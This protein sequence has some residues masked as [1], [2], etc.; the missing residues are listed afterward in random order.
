[1]PQVQQWTKAIVQRVMNGTEEIVCHRRMQQ[2][3]NQGITGV[4]A[5]G[6]ASLNFA[7]VVFKKAQESGRDEDFLE[8]VVAKETVHVRL[9]S[10][11]YFGSS[12]KRPLFLQRIIDICA[13]WSV[14]HI[15][16]SRY[17]FNPQKYAQGLVTCILMLKIYAVFHCLTKH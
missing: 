10:S 12:N 7:R 9:S 8:A 2:Y 3:G 14:I 5:C 4:S 16:V 11:F 17:C 6:L 1:M 15:L 13:G